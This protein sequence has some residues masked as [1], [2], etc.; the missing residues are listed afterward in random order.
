[1]N[2]ATAMIDS[3]MTE[4]VVESTLLGT[5]TVHA[6]QVFKFERGILGFPDTR[7]FA[8]VR[9][10]GEGMFWLQ[11][12]EFEALTFLLVDPF[13]YVEEY[14]VD[15]GPQDLGELNPDDASEMLVLSIMTLP[16]KKG[17][18]ATV[19]LQGPIALNL[20]MM[21]GR[22]VVLQ[23]SPYGVRHP[24]QLLEKDDDQG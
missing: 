6:D 23:D 4:T 14:S 18:T 13:R 20:A 3:E 5:I 12:T 22:Q 16:R 7:T 1:M 19:N 24:V 21:R 11:S 8:L 9:A 15:L 17:D 2:A 10:N